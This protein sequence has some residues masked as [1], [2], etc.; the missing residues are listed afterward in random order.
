[1]QSTIQVEQVIGRVLRQ[2]GAQHYEAEVLNTANFYV[3][4]DS[5]TV[6]A[7]VVD[8]VS[9][10]LAVDLPDVQIS[11]YD[12]RQKKRPSASA[13]KSVRTVPHIYRDPTAAKDH[14]DQII[15]NLLDFRGDVWSSA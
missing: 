10:R 4:V 9:K 13:P 8:E 12:S 1:M 3:R 11:T 15:R 2:P 7:D 6:F 14:I 5:K